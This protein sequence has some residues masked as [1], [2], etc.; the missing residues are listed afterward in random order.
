MPC[1]IEY[2]GQKKN[3]RPHRIDYK[4]NVWI[5][6]YIWHAYITPI[7]DE[8]AGSIITICLYG[9]YKKYSTRPQR[10]LEPLCFTSLIPPYSFFSPFF[11][12]FVVSV[13]LALIASLIRISPGLCKTCPAAPT[14]IKFISQ[15]IQVLRPNDHYNFISQFDFSWITFVSRYWT[16]LFQIIF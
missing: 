10:S 13:K 16:K 9:P 7:L 11:P 6:Y 8:A 4:Y 3:E 14:P 15:L 12:L 2:A 5:M 1:R